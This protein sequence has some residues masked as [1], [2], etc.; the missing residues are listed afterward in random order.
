MSANAALIVAWGGF[1]IGLV[2]GFVGDRTQFCTLGAVSDIV[3]M[4]DWGRMR[5]WL[6][7][8]G[9]A[10]VGANGL[11]LS[12][13]IDLDKSI[14]RTPTFAW[15]AYVIGG[16]FFGAGMT[17]ASGCGTK[18]LIRIGNGNLKSV[19]VFLVLGI[20]AYM[21]LRG[22]LAVVRIETLDRVAIH[23][24]G[25][26][27]LPT[28]LSGALG[29]S[30][31]ALQIL[32]TALLGGG[33]VIL[34]L[35]RREGR[36]IE[37]LLGGVAVG[38]AIVAGWY[39]TGHVGY[40][41]NP[42]TLEMTHF[43]TNSN[44]PES[45]TNVAPFAYTLELFMLWT[46]ASRTVTFAIAV[47]FGIVVGSAVNSL[48]CGRFRIE[49]FRSAEDT[50]THLVGA[51]L[52]GFGG[53]VAMGCTFGQGITGISTLAVG[54]IVTFFAIIAGAVATLRF[55]YWRISREEDIA[56]ARLK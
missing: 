4:N 8:I 28:V 18:T 1:A 20:V 38:L 16:L 5:M 31:R 7:A 13:L 26:Q 6:L 10:V 17:L 9:V 41:E 53:V 22:V 52:M 48:L 49:G 44:R 24:R 21:T 30:R 50:A 23:V 47:V 54:S 43:G 25:G 36:S 33:L 42:D 2:I 29:A 11:E 56:P 3:T 32:V 19:V 55:Q 39:L 45:V 12:G 15:L 35:A 27:D 34:A 37:H 14:Y 40:G 51:A 46:D